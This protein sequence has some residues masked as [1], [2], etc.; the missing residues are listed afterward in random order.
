MEQYIR[1]IA[2]MLTLISLAMLISFGADVLY[3]YWVLSKKKRRWGNIA[4]GGL[5][6]LRFKLF[7]LAIILPVVL[8]G[9]YRSL[10]VLDIS[11]LFL[12]LNSH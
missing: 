11:A 3:S 6:R 12:L 10:Q 1:S 8:I 4:R 2:L 9:I 5:R 7:N